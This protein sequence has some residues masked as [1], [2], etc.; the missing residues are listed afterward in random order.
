MRELLILTIHLKLRTTV[1]RRVSIDVGTVFS[2][3]WYFRLPLAFEIVR[4]NVAATR[5]DPVMRAV[6]LARQIFP[7]VWHR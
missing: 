4:G 3:H 7:V 1:C 6:A 5:T 2:A